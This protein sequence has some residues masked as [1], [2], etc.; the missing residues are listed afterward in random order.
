M[1]RRQGCLIALLAAALGMVLIAAAAAGYVMQV[2][3]GRSVPNETF[4]PAPTATLTSLPRPTPTATSA[5]TQVPASTPIILTNPT[6]EE[7]T[8]AWESAAQGQ[9]LQVFMSE[10]HIQEEFAP[11]VAQ[12]P[13]A[14]IQ[15]Q[16]VALQD[17]LITLS[18]ATL[19]SGLQVNMTASARPIL[20]NCWFNI[21]LVDAKVGRLPAPRLVM[22]EL[23]GLI[24]QWNAQAM[25]SPPMC[26]TNI[27]IAAGQLSFIGTK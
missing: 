19:M 13:Q 15:L 18:G 17:G 5:L 2:D 11:L 23:K 8:T 14:S 21:E 3:R 26:I 6:V 20:S 9:V 25:E 27:T 10:E 24:A 1:S 12:V 22:Q 7:I 16:D 4:S